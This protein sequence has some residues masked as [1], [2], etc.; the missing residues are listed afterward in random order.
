M[1]RGVLLDIGGTLVEVTD[2]V[3]IIHRFLEDR[4]ISKSLDEVSRAVYSAEKSFSGEEFIPRGFWKEWNERVL[5]N[6]GISSDRE[7]TAA[8]IDSE[9]FVR[10]KVKVYPEVEEV[11]SELKRRGLRLG[12]VT[13]G[14]ETDLEHLIGRPGL[15]KF[16]DV[17][18]SADMVGRRKPNPRIF[19]YA[20]RKLGLP[21]SDVLSVGDD[22]DLDYRPSESIGMVPLLIDRAGR[23]T[24]VKNLAPDL[25]GVF[26]FL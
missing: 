25:R 7:L 17:V 18:V 24:L 2:P 19:L 20:S 3:P 14:V 22:P 9:W 15:S 8:Q 16:F 4:G 6:L 10:S 26:D 13:N 11:L 5:E 21:P 12:A 23:R 1:I